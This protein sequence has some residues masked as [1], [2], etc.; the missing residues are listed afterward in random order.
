MLVSPLSLY[1]VLVAV[2]CTQLEKIQTGLLNVRQKEEVSPGAMKSRLA[3]CV[4]HHQKVMRWEINS[5]NLVLLVVSWKEENWF[6]NSAPRDKKKNYPVFLKYEIW[7]ILPNFWKLSKMN[8][9]HRLL[10]EVIL[11]MW[12]CFWSTCYC[13][14]YYPVVIPKTNEY[15]DLTF[16]NPCVVI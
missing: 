4:K 14:L 5:Q 13:L 11:D 1:A 15:F 8:A 12:V 7:K 3:E 10:Y 16:L 2:C 6:T 9:G